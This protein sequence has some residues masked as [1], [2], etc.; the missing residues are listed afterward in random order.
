MS[1][2]VESVVPEFSSHYIFDKLFL[3]YM[4][5]RDA[6]KPYFVMWVANAELLNP[7]TEE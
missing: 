4:K 6:D 7:W 5:K 3:I 2:K 1:A